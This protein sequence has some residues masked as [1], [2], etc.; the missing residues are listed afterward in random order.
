MR[1]SKEQMSGLVD[2][3]FPQTQILSSP[4]YF[5][6][7]T[8]RRALDL[9]YDHL[10][11][12]TSSSTQPHLVTYAEGMIGDVADAHFPEVDFVRKNLMR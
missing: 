10:C 7:C 9:C 1:E 12:S 11:P 4:P 3:L 2:T 6:S 5:R 8:R